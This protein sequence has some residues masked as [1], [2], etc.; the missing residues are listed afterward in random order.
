MEQARYTYSREELLERLCEPF[1]LL[2]AEELAL[3]QGLASKDPELALAL[4]QCRAMSGL[5]DAAI[6][7]QPQ[8][9]DAQFLVALRDKLAEPATIPVLRGAFGTGGLV[10]AVAT[11]CVVV[12]VVIF[13][14][15][16]KFTPGVATMQPQ[17]VA[18]LESLASAIDPGTTVVPDSIYDQT[19]DAESLAVYLDIPDLTSNWDFETDTAELNQPLS[20][21]LLSLDTQTL[22]EVLNDLENTNFF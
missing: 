8:T 20:D 1:S 14:A 12:M 22:Q 3:V 18:A 10:G 4:R 17:D 19:V 2:T 7:G 16:S 13:A 9:S 11:V 21:E 15:G 6:Y 5:T